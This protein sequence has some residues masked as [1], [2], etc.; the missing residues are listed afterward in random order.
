MI[1]KIIYVTGCLG[2]MGSHFTRRALER[3]WTVYGVDKIT[4]AANKNLLKE[5]KKHSTFSF[6]RVDIKD[7]T[8]L[9]DCDYVVNFAAESHVENSILRSEEFIDSNIVGVKNL[10]DLIR[11]KP[12]NCNDRPTF[13]HISTDEVYGDIEEG[14]HSERDRLKPSNPYAAAK[15]AGDMLINAWNR[16]YGLNYVIMRPT[17]N[18]GAGQYP[19]KLIPLTIKNLLRDKKIKLHNRG[20]P[21]RNWLHAEDTSSAV[22]CVIDADVKNEIFNIAGGFEQANIDTVKRV[23]EGFFGDKRDARKYIDFSHNRVGQDVRY[24]LDDSKLRELGWSAQ[25]RFNDEIDSIVEYYK[26]DFTW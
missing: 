23:I 11:F 3:E 14:C 20:T 4:Y 13:L 16:T 22:M 21:I 25:K 6:E 17:N 18:Y 8:F 24:A 2:F 5:F 12:Q 9:K 7:M 19:E 15:A 26:K 1:E 10:L